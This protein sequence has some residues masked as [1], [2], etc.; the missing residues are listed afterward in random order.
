MGR[1]LEVGSGTGW[2]TDIL[3]G[4]GYEVY[5]LEPSEDMIAAARERLAGFMHH[6][7]FRTGAPV[8]YLCET[9]EEC[10]VPDG[11]IDGILF[12]ESLHHIVDEELGLAQCFRVLAPDGV[13]GVTAEA[14]WIP[15]DRNLETAC[16]EEMARYGTMENPYTFDYLHYLLRKHGFEEVTRHHAINGY[17]PEQMGGL[18]IEQAAQAPAKGSNHITARKPSDR[19]T[20]ANQRGATKGTIR[21]IDVKRGSANGKIRIQVELTNCG[22][23]LWLSEPRSAGWMVLSLGAVPKAGTSWRRS[24]AIACQTFCRPANRSGWKPSILRRPTV[25]PATGGWTWSM[26][27]SR[28]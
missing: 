1:I 14:E 2:L 16:E 11:R 23:T 6:H 8:H 12:H 22:E 9:L 20:T 13:L 24:R 10:S 7:H 26:R 25:G 4:L 28:G 18:T 3:F 19:P 15:G 21:V 5:A 27:A 17:F